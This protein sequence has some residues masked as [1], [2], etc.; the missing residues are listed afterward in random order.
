MRFLLRI[1]AGS[2]GGLLLLE[3]IFQCLPTNS[4]SF[5]Q[6]P[7]SDAQRYSH[8]QP[9]RSYNYS[10]GWDLERP[11]QGTTNSLGFANTR[12]FSSNTKALVIGDSY[13]QGLMLPYGDTLQGQ[14]EQRLGS[15]VVAASASGNG[16]AD[17]LELAR[18]FVPKTHPEMVVILVERS[19]VTDIL[20]PV[21]AGH[22]S[23]Q[24]GPEGITTQHIPYQ[25]T[26]NPNVAAVKG[27]FAQSALM[28]YLVSNIR[29]P[30]WFSSVKSKLHAQTAP[31]NPT[32]EYRQRVLNYYLQQLN[33]LAQAQDTKFVF[34]VDADRGAMYSRDQRTSTKWDAD[35]RNAFIQAVK[36]HGFA[37]V[38]TKPLFQRHWDTKAER[39]DFLP[40]D[41]HWNSVAH[42]LAA[43]EIVSQLGNSLTASGKTA[44]AVR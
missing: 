15:G 26:S 11:Q 41:G 23:F 34:V 4:T 13:V 8:Y 20:T 5:M 30:D 31:A 40:A 32:P 17:S 3:G 25:K 29:L 42:R 7:T 36:A 24:I 38:D 33:V 27:F 37:V 22:S 44:A 10:F 43:Q 28:R 16:L 2:I 35:S 18:E 12:E 1:A 19:D 39:L 9:N 14:L 21:T 6:A